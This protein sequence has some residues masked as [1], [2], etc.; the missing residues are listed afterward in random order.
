MPVIGAIL[1]PLPIPLPCV[2]YVLRAGEAMHALLPRRPRPRGRPSRT[3]D[4][5]FVPFTILRD[6]CDRNRLC[7]FRWPAQSMATGIAAQA[8]IPPFV[9]G[10]STARHTFC[11]AGLRTGGC[12]G[13]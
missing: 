2:M 6:A 4:S 8:A 10:R 9:A 12:F 3:R 13:T 1:V 11:R 5:D 7:R